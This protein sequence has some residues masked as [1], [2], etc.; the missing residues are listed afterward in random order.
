MISFKGFNFYF[1]EFDYRL[2][3][4]STKYEMSFS[5]SLSDIQYLSLKLI[6]GNDYPKECLINTM[7][8]HING[9]IKYIEEQNEYNNS[10]IRNIRT[11]Y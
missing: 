8:R 5:M 9:Y 3:A 7:K 6:G 11:K 10:K 1:N 4:W 2:S